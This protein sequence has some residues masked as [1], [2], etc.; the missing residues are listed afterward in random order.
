[1]KKIIEFFKNRIVIS[2]IGLIAL[3]VLIW[4]AGP[5]I[6]FGEDNHAPLGGVVARL[7]AIICIVALWGLNNLR[8]QLMARKQNNELMEDL[9]ENQKEAAADLTAEQSAEELHQMGQRFSDALATL[10]KLKFNGGGRSQALYELPWY[11]IIGP[12]G[13]GK[14]TA[15]VN[16]SL[17]FP[18]ATQFG[19]GAVQGIGG[20]RNCDWWFTN[21]AVL[22]DTAG[23][24]TTQDSH[25][26]VDST[27]WEGFL[28]LLKKNRPRRPINGA[29]IAISIHDLLFQTDDERAQHAKTIRMRLDELME[30]LAIRFPIY[31]MFT[32]TDLVSGFTEYFED[33]T[34][35]EREQVWGITLPDA[36]GPAQ[37]PDHEFLDGEFQKLLDR[38]YSRQLSRMHSERDVRRRGAIQSFP[39]QMENLK[40]VVVD[41]VRQAFVKNRY[42]FQPYLRGIYFTSGTQDGTPIDRMMTSVS[43]NFGFTRESANQSHNQGKSFFL[44]NLFKQVMFPESELVGS[45]RRYEIFIKWLQRGAYVSLALVT[46]GLLTVWAGSVSRHNAF[47]S[48]VA[49]YLAEYRSQSKGISAWDKDVRAVLPPLNALAQASVVYDQDEHP[50]LSGMGLYDGQVD[51]SADAAYQSQLRQLLLPRL[52]EHL[53]KK[54]DGSER[55]GELYEAFR[56]YLMFNK[57]EHMDP[58]LVV[59]WFVRD[60]HGR[61]RGE[62]TR[63][64]QL[65]AHLKALLA[66]YDEPYPLNDRLVKSARAQLLQV[67]V[68]Q[69]I[70]SR[71]T[72]DPRLAY[73][74]DMLHQFGGTVQDVFVITP[75]VSA[76]LQIPYIFT[77]EGYESLDFSSDSPLIAEVVNER[78][79]LSD[80]GTERV[81]FA[82]SDFDDIGEKVKALYLADY[83]AHWNRLFSSLSIAKFTSI[84]QA[85]DVLASMTDPVYSPLVSVLRVSA[86]NTTLSNQL[87]QNINDDYGTGKRGIVT[88]ALAEKF[89][90]TTVDR[91]YRALN[92]LLRESDKKPAPISAVMDKLQDLQAFVSEIAM[93]SDPNKKAFEVAKA[94]YQTGTG[95]AITAL[96]THSTVLPEPMQRWIASLSDHAWQVVLASGRAYVNSEWKA[97]VH[98]NYAKALEGRYPL[99]RTSRSELA[100]YDFSGFFKPKGIMDGFYTEFIRPFVDTRRGLTNRVVDG[101][102]MGFSESTLAQIGRA[103]KITAVFFRTNPEIP[104]ISFRLMPDRMAKNDARFELEVGAQ[105]IAYNHGP[106]FWKSL[107]W[108]GAEEDRRV[109]VVFQ[110]LAGNYHEAEY[111]GPWAWFR[112][113]DRSRLQRT[114]QSNIYKAT[115]AVAGDGREHRIDYLIKADSVDNPF[116]EDLLTS[117][118]C[119]ENI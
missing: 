41:F 58:T 119:P 113:Q 117:F 55:G 90:G 111:D 108:S 95:N 64:Q 62:A 44:G 2:I 73:T 1:M 75:E 91:E 48:D 88:N 32:K 78:W 25:K 40:S 4:F 43:S 61:M 115:Y 31:L 68:Q 70:Y 20:T 35:E 67:P 110:D 59:N 96:R 38:L 46:V 45:N 52:I 97:R 57:I 54:I 89:S 93:A 82:R 76:N 106:K 10:K 9:G 109:R 29:I 116:R 63:K 6:K 65:E 72:T 92:V 3:A 114:K 71:L 102:S 21:D 14:T 79:V 36:P 26:V 53:E 84:A 77:K 23:R 11:I 107:T 56:V 99:N 16:S 83:V 66:H 87:M 69:R 85:R 8:V 86:E 42:Q 103:Q 30:K 37:S 105:R 100:L 47:M 27:A 49:S 33:L 101:A 118:R 112:L 13:S 12:P 34:K 80:D 104:G 94:R 7:I 39:Q 18:L 5:W 19:K 17:E 22:I 50:W 74:V 24:Y 15:L 51:A 60:W 81:D 98:D 28:K